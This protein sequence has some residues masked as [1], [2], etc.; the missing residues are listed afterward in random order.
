LPSFRLMSG[1]IRSGYPIRG[2]GRSRMHR[3]F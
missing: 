2:L 1:I 3:R